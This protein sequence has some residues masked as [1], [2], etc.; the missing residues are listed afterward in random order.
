MHELDYSHCENTFNSTQEL[1]EHLKEHLE[2]VR[3]RIFRELT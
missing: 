1:G 3:Y 2:E